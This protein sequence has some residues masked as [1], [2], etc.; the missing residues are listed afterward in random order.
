LL[1]L[2]GSTGSILSRPYSVVM[3]GEQIGHLLIELAE[4]VLDYSGFF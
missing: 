2:D 4:M 1:G 3:G